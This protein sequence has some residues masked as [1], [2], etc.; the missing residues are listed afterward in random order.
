MKKKKKWQSKE[1]RV[2]AV[3]RPAGRRVVTKKEGK[4]WKILF[5]KLYIDLLTTKKKKKK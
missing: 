5:R 4:K 1:P 2:I 3:L